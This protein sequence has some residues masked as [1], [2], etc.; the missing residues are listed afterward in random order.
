M[1]M[2][3]LVSAI[4]AM[5][6]IYIGYV[7]GRNAINEIIFN[8]LTS[9]K[10]SKKY[11]I[12][13]Y[14]H[15]I[16]N[17]TE[18]L[19]ENEMIAQALSDFKLG[20][21][22]IGK[23]ELDSECS[24]RLS[25]HYDAFVDHVSQ[26]MDIK[27]NP[28]L[29]YPKST[30]ACYLQYEY[31]IENPNPSGDKHLLL[32]AND[33]SDYNRAHLK[34]HK[35]LTDAI[36]KFGF[37]DIFLIDLERGDI[38]YTAYKETDFATNLYSGPYK[39][40]N[41]A[42]LARKLRSNSDIKK[43]TFT[44]F[45]NYRPSYG[46][47]AAFV[48]IPITEGAITLGALVLQLP[49]GEINKIMTGDNNWATDGLGE[50]GE[51]YLVGEDYLMR[52]I[53]RFYLQDTVGYTDALLDL[54]VDREEVDKMYR[55][56]TTILHQRVKTEG[57][58][59]AL[60]GKNETKVIEDYR[61]TPVLSSYAPL[62][63]RGMNWVILS[64]ID[65]AEAN[66]PINQFKKKVFIALCI[67]ILIVTFLAM[68]LASR[69]VQPIEK[70]SEGVRRLNDGD[71]SQEID[72]Q[73]KDEFGELASSF[74][75]M[76]HNIEKQQDVIAE[77]SMRN[78]KLLLN[79]IPASIATRLQKGEKNIANIYPNVSLIAIDI[80][81]FSRLATQI[82]PAESISLL[83]HLVE[84]F[85][86]TAEKHQIEKIRTVGDTYFAACGMFHPRLDH[87]KKIFGFALEVRQLATQF[88]INY[89]INLA[90]HIG[91]H[92]GEVI[93]GIVGN[94]KFNYD[95]WGQTVNETFALKDIEEDNQIFVSDS[96]YQKLKE[97]YEFEKY[98]IKETSKLDL[99]VWKYAEQRI[100]N[101]IS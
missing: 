5:V 89:N 46:A 96:V 16:E 73:S 72:I 33:G 87:A 71:Y 9:V 6:L 60:A 95:L 21:R 54:G 69:F 93:A 61:F 76:T 13:S 50:S 97:Q 74:N 83:N 66:I 27:N 100:K 38:V 56:G 42:E 26:N 80:H 37:Y 58:T 15:E 10:A 7:N 44:D 82:G 101:K 99:E 75:E 8:Q 32:D 12:E 35:Y 52:S 45:E 3:I 81:G 59:E 20:Y 62:D 77:Q 40:S 23:N 28:E 18:V 17:I 49:V 1:L 43:A 53:S 11:Q 55:I 14:F 92:S 98:T 22:K 24:Q 19:G 41:L 84:A 47:P 65:Q 48:G 68:Y 78:E 90:L 85:D 31:I 25:T 30:E 57:V 79:F 39:E 63:I 88:N 29:Y 64:E 36:L 67:I 94:E 4:S 70:L 51:T 2:L 86:Q 91:I 34:Y